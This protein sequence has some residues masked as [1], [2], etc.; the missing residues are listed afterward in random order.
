MSSNCGL[1]PSANT[2][3]RRWPKIVEISALPRSHSLSRRA[4]ICERRFA[5]LAML[6]RFHS[7]DPSAVTARFPC[8]HCQS[9]RFSKWLLIF[10]HY[11]RIILRAKLL[12]SRRFELLVSDQKG[13]QECIPSKWLHCGLRSTQRQSASDWMPSEW[14][15]KLNFDRVISPKTSIEGIFFICGFRK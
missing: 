10:C 5:I 2:G 3:R 11:S 9:V 14:L 4:P 8:S 7:R 6:T 1:W 13:G 15:K 12:E